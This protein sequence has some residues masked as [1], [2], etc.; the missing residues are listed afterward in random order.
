MFLDHSRVS[1][2]TIPFDL[3]TEKAVE[4]LNDVKRLQ[5]SEYHL[6]SSKKRIREATGGEMAGFRKRL[7]S[8]GNNETDVQESLRIYTE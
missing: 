2:N 7:M 3:C 4:F 1:F 8:R 6:L 5:P